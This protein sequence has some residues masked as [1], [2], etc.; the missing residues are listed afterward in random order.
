MATIDYID[1]PTAATRLDNPDN[2]HPAHRFTT[3]L[4]KP[5]SSNGRHHR[6]GSGYTASSGIASALIPQIFMGSIPATTSVPPAANSSG[7]PVTSPTTANSRR[8][9]KTTL[10][11][12]KDPLSLPIMTNNF[13][14]FVA[15][16]GPVFWFQ[17][18]VEEILFWKRGWKHTATW[19]A[20]YTFLCYFPRMI[21]LLPHGILIGVILSTYPYASST[22]SDDGAS[23][24]PAAQQSPTEGTAAWQANIQAIQ[25]LMGFISDTITFA[26]PYAYHLSLTPSQLSSPTT[27]K[28]SPYTPHILTILVVTFFPLLILVHLPGFPIREV[29]LFAGLAPFVVT[30]PSVQS[31]ATSFLSDIQTQL[32]PGL[33]SRYDRLLSYLINPHIAK[34]M[35]YSPWQSTIERLIDNDRLPDEIWSAEKKE[36]ELFEN[37]RYD[38]GNS[39]SSTSPT[40]LNYGMEFSNEQG[41][42]KTNLRPGERCAWTRGRDG[43]TGIGPNDEISSNLTFS[44]APNWYFIPTEDWRRDLKGEWC[45]GE[46][47][48]EDGWAYTNDSWVIARNKP[49]TDGGGSVTRRRRWI[50]RVWFDEKRRSDSGKP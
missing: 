4:P 2:I 43:W 10:L 46:G 35:F 45:E 30:H 1:I 26:Q 23:P 14:R 32:I 33:I 15:K 18:R 34:W 5:D 50:R 42:S 27:T 16:V 44:L 6:S 28:S 41:W 39:N 38:S 9:E 7:T 47:V 3:N 21:L 48:D 40:T 12:S 13:K 17:D 22:T 8:K 19:M 11:T 24:V 31:T 29:A 25:N 49:Y 37:E 36:V 20:L